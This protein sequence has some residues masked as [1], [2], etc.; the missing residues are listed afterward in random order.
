[1]AHKLAGSTASIAKAKAVADIVK[2][3]LKKLNKD[4]TGDTPTTLSFDKVATELLLHHSILETKFLLL[5]KSDAVVTLFATGST[6]TV[7][8]GRIRAAL[9]SLGG[10]EKSHTKAAADF[11]SWACMSCHFFVG[12]SRLNAGVQLNASGFLGTATVMR[13]GSHIL[14]SCHFNAESLN[15]TNRRF[16][17]GTR[18]FHTDFSLLETVGHGLATSVLGNELGSVGGAFARPTKAHLTRTGPANH[19]TAGIT[20]GDDG[21]VERSGNV[22]HPSLDVLTTLGFENLR[23]LG[24]FSTFELEEDVLGCSSLFALLLFSGSR[25]FLGSSTG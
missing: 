13:N 24:T 7:L 18:T 2:T 6:G 3:G 23:R 11:V 16:A 17:T 19:V 20:D 9:Q 12:N 1:M 22:N 21:V 25:L 5:R 4:V 14:D 10:A 8:A 15:G